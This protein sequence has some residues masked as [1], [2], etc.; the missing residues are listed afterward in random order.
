MRLRHQALVT[1]AGWSFLAVLAVGLVTPSSARADL[2]TNGDFEAGNTGFTTQYSVVTGN[3]TVYTSPG[4][5]GI[6]SNPASSTT[7]FTNGYLS[8]GDH[9]SG[10]GLMLFMDGGSPSDYFWQE[11]VSLA[12]ST[13]YTFSYYV[14]AAYDENLPTIQTLLNGTGLDFRRGRHR[15][16]R[17]RY[18]WHWLAGGYRHFHDDDCWD[19]H[20]VNV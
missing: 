1:T 9:T 14:T 5:T 11:L 15:L 7:G 18:L 8:Y 19:L 12:A 16:R 4:D 20:V 6:T 2:L 13:E 10:S 17:Y 3:G